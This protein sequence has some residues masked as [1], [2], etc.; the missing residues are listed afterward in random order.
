MLTVIDMP[1]F[2]Y[3]EPLFPGD[4]SGTCVRQLMRKGDWERPLLYE[5]LIETLGH[6]HHYAASQMCLHVKRHQQI[7]VKQCNK[8][9]FMCKLLTPFHLL[10]IAIS[11]MFRLSASRVWQLSHK[12]TAPLG[13]RANSGTS[14][15]PEKIEV[16][17]DDQPVYVDPG[18]TVL[19][20]W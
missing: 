3:D 17:V 20:V 1:T 18:T 6:Y 16:F 12:L 2:V 9:D 7:T 8:H 5:L 13:A 4:L 11:A 19:Q 10:W 15:A 14:P